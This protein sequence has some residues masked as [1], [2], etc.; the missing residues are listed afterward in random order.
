MKNSENII[1]VFF[2]VKPTLNPSY[3]VLLS[4]EHYNTH[5]ISN[6]EK[7]S[8]VTKCNEHNETEYSPSHS[9]NRKQGLKGIKNRLHASTPVDSNTLSPEPQIDKEY[10]II[11]EE[12]IIKKEKSKLKNDKYEEKPKKRKNKVLN[13]CETSIV[14]NSID[15]TKFEEK[16]KRK[17]KKRKI[18]ITKQ[19]EIAENC[20]LNSEYDQTIK[21]SRL[22]E[23]D[24]TAAEINEEQSI[25]DKTEFISK[26][27]P[28]KKARE[29]NT[30]SSEPLPKTTNLVKITKVPIEA[31]EIDY[32]RFDFS[33]DDNFQMET[34]EMKNLN[35]NSLVNDVSNQQTYISDSK[36]TENIDSSLIIQNTSEPSH[37]CLQEK[38]RISTNSSECDEDPSKT[39]I[40]S[41]NLNNSETSKVLFTS[42][43]DIQIEK[44]AVTDSISDKSH[45]NSQDDE[46]ES[47]NKAR[48]LWR[49][50]ISKIAESSDPSSTSESNTNCAKS[51]IDTEGN[52]KSNSR[53]D[54]NFSLLIEDTL[55]LDGKT[56][57]SLYIEEDSLQSF[58]TV[59][60]MFYSY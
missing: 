34:S 41:E 32:S 58:T 18:D 9:K 5:T 3:S 52:H 51:N 46:S 6:N 40:V 30:W 55:K 47:K 35:K 21:K 1:Y 43:C 13:E 22:T 26:P 33:P 37:N 57:S 54:E 17:T 2:S 7:K 4:S 31:I 24:K 36:K 23:C 53:I 20:S 59:T 27:L 19:E 11:P 8:N 56:T 45:E 12:A 44:Q 16:Y 49:Q 42:T 60:G 39:N 50:K 28:H 10:K 38:I 15:E 29:G 14:D 48:V 25:T